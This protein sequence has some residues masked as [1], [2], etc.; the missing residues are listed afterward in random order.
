VAVVVVV[1]GTSSLET[2]NSAGHELLGVPWSLWMDVSQMKND[3][4]K[5]QDPER[6][7]EVVFPVLPW[8]SSDLVQRPHKGCRVQRTGQ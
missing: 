5:Q 7:A 1:A 8:R 4:L 6:N 3:G 2:R